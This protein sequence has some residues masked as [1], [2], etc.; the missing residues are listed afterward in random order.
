LAPYPCAWT[1]MPQYDDAQIKI[2]ET[3][4]LG[5]G[6]SASKGGWPVECGENT[7]LEILQ[8]KPAGKKAMRASDYLRGLRNEALPVLR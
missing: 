2:L 5:E 7:R 1:T 8:V 3:R 4:V 6:E